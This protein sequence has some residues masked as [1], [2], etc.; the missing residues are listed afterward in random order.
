MSHMR[1]WFALRAVAWCAAIVVSLP[2]A[3]RALAQCLDWRAEQLEGRIAGA[4][5]AYDTDRG[6]AVLFGGYNGTTVVN[7]TQEWKGQGWKLRKTNNAPSIRAGAMMAYDPVRKVTVL[8]GGDNGNFGYLNDTWEYNGINWTLKSIPGAKPSA[9]TEGAMVYDPVRNVM[10]LF[11][12]QTD[13]AQFGD[14]WEYNGTTWTERPISGP[15]ARYLHAMAYDEANSRVVLYGGWASFFSEFDTWAYDG[16]SWT[17]ILPPGQTPGRLYAHAM[18]YDPTLGAVLVYG[19]L[20]SGF[21]AQADVWRLDGDS[22]AQVTDINTPAPGRAFHSIVHDA[23]TGNML[24][25]GGDALGLTWSWQTGLWARVDTG[26]PS[27]RTHGAFTFDTSRGVAVLFG[28]YAGNILGDT[29]EWDGNAWKQRL[30]SGGPP[31]G[32]ASPMEFD[33]SIA[34]S[35][36]AVYGDGSQMHTWGWDGTV[37]TLLD[38]NGPDNRSQHMLTY[39]QTRQRMVLF[40]GYDGANNLGDTWEWDGASWTR[41]A[42]TGPTPRW[43]GAMA[44]DPA[45]GGIVLYGGTTG[46]TTFDDTWL[47]DGVSWTEIPGANQPGTRVGHAMVYHAERGRIVVFGRP[48]VNT[49]FE[50]VGTTWQP[51]T[52]A[53]DAPPGRWLH[54][55]AYDPVRKQALMFGGS[56]SG[57]SGWKN[58][59]WALGDILRV[60]HNP[61]SQRV[62]LGQTVQFQVTAD[63]RS[64]LTYRWHR[65]GVPLSGGSGISGATSRTLTVGPIAMSHLGSY[66]CVVTGSCGT[67]TSAAA[68]LSLRCNGDFNR[69]GIVDILDLLDYLNAYAA[70]DGQPAPCGAGGPDADINGDTVVDILDLLDFLNDFGA[71]CD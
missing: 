55:M 6:V 34:Q 54:M 37:W 32:F 53:G 28:G 40:G 50:L 48:F 35:I 21:V 26:R 5:M 62:D 15:P 63:G 12:G 71:G 2:S 8:F 44:H 42:T 59:L 61:T 70:C 31:A 66:T 64:G 11:G 43:S 36:L 57:G 27:V 25:H 51:I 18:A 68:T 14:T 67:V 9:R 60:V 46:P 39:D 52:Y 24:I 19:G 10:V 3:P 13:V 65:D 47:W 58:D 7:S 17:Q 22:W 33:P 1:C 29:W 16:T 20:D 45:L 38:T 69:D 30:A 56:A 4:S 49:A 41:V 23:S